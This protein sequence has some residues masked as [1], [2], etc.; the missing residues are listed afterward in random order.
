MALIKEHNRVIRTLQQHKE[1]INAAAALI[2]KT[3]ESGNKLLLCGNGGSAA[4]CQH[5]AAEFMVRYS[6]TRLPLPA[7][8]LTTD[9]SLITAH[10]NDFDFATLYSRQ[11]EALG[12][13]NDL[14]IAISTSGNS[15]NII[16]ACQMAKQKDIRVIT[17]TGNSNGLSPYADI[18]IKVNSTITARI[19]E[20]HIFIGHYLCEVVDNHLGKK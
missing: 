8:A 10:T 12:N 20:A 4:D 9:S 17:L 11:I 2:I 6:K 19:Q 3:F 15:K 5:I 18:C 7:I 1:S 14:L 16:Y 13:P